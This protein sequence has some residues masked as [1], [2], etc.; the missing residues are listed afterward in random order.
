MQIPLR[1]RRIL[2][3]TAMRNKNLKLW[4]K[5]V[6]VKTLSIILTHLSSSANGTLSWILLPAKGEPKKCNTQ[7]GF[8]GWNVNECHKTREETKARLS[9]LPGGE[10][11]F[12]VCY[13]HLIIIDLSLAKKLPRFRGRTETNFC[14]KT[15]TGSTPYD[16]T[17]HHRDFSLGCSVFHRL[18]AALKQIRESS[19]G[20]R[21][22]MEKRRENFYDIL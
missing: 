8:S 16:T 17:I 13:H 19:G 11:T 2:Y 20:K 4:M 3:A 1:R 14:L 7:R 10:E 18:F 6:T 21:N 9:I 12:F 22:E 5:V 15:T